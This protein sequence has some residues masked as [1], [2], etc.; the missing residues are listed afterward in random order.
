MKKI[1]IVIIVLFLVVIVSGSFNEMKIIEEPVI[2]SIVPLNKSITVECENGSTRTCSGEK[3]FGEDHSNNGNIGWCYCY[4]IN[5]DGTK[6]NYYQAC[7][8]PNIR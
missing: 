7:D 5:S 1:F 8:K 2:K 3:C 4:T 6:D